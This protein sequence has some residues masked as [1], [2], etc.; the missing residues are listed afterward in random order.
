M[1][2]PTQRYLVVTDSS[3]WE[4]GTYE[5][6]CEVA[7][8]LDARVEV[9]ERQRDAKGLYCWVP[10]D[11]PRNP[12][13]AP[14]EFLATDLPGDDAAPVQHRKRRA[15]VRSKKRGASKVGSKR[16]RVAK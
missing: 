11:S 4:Y 9:Q 10:V 16:R 12:Q 1:A 15:G 6:A 8:S 14:C 5:R 7:K 13:E 3:G 2:L